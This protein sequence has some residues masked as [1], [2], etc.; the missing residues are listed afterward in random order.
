MTYFKFLIYT[1]IF[2]ISIVTNAQKNQYHEDGTRHGVWEK[3]FE[4]TEQV[5][6]S[7]Q[8]DHGVEIGD[9]KFYSK[10]FPKQATAIK[11]FSENGKKAQI[12]FYSQRGK[13]ISQG[14]EIDRK[15]E[16]KWE[17]YHNNSDKIMMVEYYENGLLEGERVSY[18][19]SG[20]V[21]EKISF[22]NGKKHG[23]QLVY[24]V[25]EVL[26]KEFTYANDELNGVNK[27]F[28]GRGI[29]SIE[30]IYKDDKKQGVWKYYDA[31]GNLIN[32]KRYR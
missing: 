7:G 15:K 24:S 16:G 19:E 5:R 13:L 8:F 20:V 17:Y 4:G 28:T 26:I 2:I 10:G 14:V 29:L 6:Y 21:S 9:F 27:F 23:K 18:Y 30:G 31:T 3:K 32:E 22:L 12:R 1:L 11:T 25:K